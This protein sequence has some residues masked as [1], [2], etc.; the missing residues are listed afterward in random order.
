[1]LNTHYIIK[2]IFVS[3]I[4]QNLNLFIPVF[5]RKITLFL[6]FCHIINIDFFFRKVEVSSF[7][8][9]IYAEWKRGNEPVSVEGFY[10]HFRKM[11]RTWSDENSTQRAFLLHLFFTEKTFRHKQRFFSNRIFW[12]SMQFDQRKMTY[13]HVTIVARKIMMM[14]LITTWSLPK[15]FRILAVEKPGIISW[16]RPQ[17]RRTRHSFLVGIPNPGQMLDWGRI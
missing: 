17:P 6:F 9:N 12:K 16:T 10:S 4:W 1:M 15:I 2:I 3:I 13:M 7:E 8:V 14:K 11:Q 5:S